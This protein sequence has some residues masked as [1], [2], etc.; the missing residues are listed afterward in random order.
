MSQHALSL[1][2]FLPGVGAANSGGGDNGHKALC[3]LSRHVR[4][5]I[6]LGNDRAY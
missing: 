5:G 4:L 3:P 1:L 2:E 6:M